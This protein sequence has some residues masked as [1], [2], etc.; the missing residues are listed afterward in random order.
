MKIKEIKKLIQSEKL[1]SLNKL[2]TARA[3]ENFAGSQLADKI[4]SMKK[5]DLQIPESNKYRKKNTDIEKTNLI[6]TALN[7]GSHLLMNLDWCNF[8][9]V[10]WNV[11]KL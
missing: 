7:K 10:K 8:S 11:K 5:Y 2:K 1:Q 9:I 6:S 3:I 4:I